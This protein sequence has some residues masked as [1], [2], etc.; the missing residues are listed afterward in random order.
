MVTAFK[1]RQGI[2]YRSTTNV[3]Q[4]TP[5]DSE[6]VIREFHKQIRSFAKR[7]EKKGAFGQYELQDIGNM[8]QTP[9]PKLCGIV[10]L[11]LD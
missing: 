5:S 10:E 3:S 11:H 4:K 9:L 2:S 8:D 1:R 7:G 6:S